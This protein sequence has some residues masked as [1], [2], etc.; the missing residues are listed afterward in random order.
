M[1]ETITVT[2]DGQDKKFYKVE[3][4]TTEEV[5][6]KQTIT[7]ASVEDKIT[8]LQENIAA[9]QDQI[10]ELEILKNKIVPKIDEAALNP[11]P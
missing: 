2:P 3:I 11:V 1:T 8:I 10:S 4:S 6:K 7:L 9:I 5:T